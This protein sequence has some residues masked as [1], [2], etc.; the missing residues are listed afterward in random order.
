MQGFKSPKLAIVVL[1]K[2]FEA[3]IH[4]FLNM[5]NKLASG[6][7]TVKQ[8]SLAQLNFGPKSDFNQL[9]RF[10]SNSAIRPSL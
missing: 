4:T 3:P 7:Q 8:K 9:A 5:N 6:K 2:N 10:Y 1:I